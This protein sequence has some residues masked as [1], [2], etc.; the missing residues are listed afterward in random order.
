VLLVHERGAVLGWKGEDMS[1][2][3]RWGERGGGGLGEDKLNGR[4][5][6]AHGF[7]RKA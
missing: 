7:C 6:G 5:R 4:R 1:V 3:G 2:W